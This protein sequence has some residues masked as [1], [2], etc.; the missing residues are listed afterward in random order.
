MAIGQVGRE[1]LDRFRLAVGGVGLIHGPYQKENPRQ[2]PVHKYVATGF[3]YAQAVIAML[4]PWLGEVKREQ[5]RRVLVGYL[6]QDWR[7]GGPRKS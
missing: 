7:R 3:K 4:W 2:K 1:L 6:T 5:A